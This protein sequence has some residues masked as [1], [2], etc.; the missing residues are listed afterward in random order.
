MV[1]MNSPDRVMLDTNIFD[2]LLAD[3]GAINVLNDLTKRSLVV[4]LT[5]HVQ[6]DELAAIPDVNAA[7]RVSLEAVY[8]Q[9]DM[10]EIPTSG[11]IWGVSRFDRSMWGD[12]SGSLRI[13]DIMR[14]NPKDAEDALIAITAAA[15]ADIFVTA[16]TKE[17]PNRI[18]AKGT[19]LE[20][21]SFEE[22]MAR[23]RALSKGP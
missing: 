15:S 8:R 13:G 16:E 1:P 7:R 10:T 9:L 4:I 21:L 14:S 22:F 12:G 6:A 23:M 2:K 17:L 19:A 18:K 3:P 5:T 20:V 11:A